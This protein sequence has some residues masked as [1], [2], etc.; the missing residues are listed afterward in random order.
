MK[1]NNEKADK[2]LTKEESKKTEKG[3]V[4][5][6]EKNYIE[7]LTTERANL[8]QLSKRKFISVK[9]IKQIFALLLFDKNKTMTEVMEELAL[10][11][12][13]L[14]KWRKEFKEKR[15]DSLFVFLE[16][17]KDD[18]RKGDI[19]ENESNSNSSE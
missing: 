16:K 13:T 19:D 11:P 15:M 2:E 6:I 14:L 1:K 3:K 12:Q 5:K 8:K 4:K 18:D 10:S 9:A 17:K 7:L